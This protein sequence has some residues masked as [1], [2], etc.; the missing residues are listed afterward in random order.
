MAIV[1][2]TVE[3][4]RYDAGD[5]TVHVVNASDIAV[6]KGLNLSCQQYHSLKYNV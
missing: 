4:L 3:H 2:V 6:G 1:R 5:N